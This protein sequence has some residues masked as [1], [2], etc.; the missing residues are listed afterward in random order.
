MVAAFPL[1]GPPCEPESV[2]WGLDGALAASSSLAVSSGSVPWDE[3]WHD[4]P[5]AV[6]ATGVDGCVRA[7]ASSTLAAGLFWTV[8]SGRLLFGPRLAEVIAA[9]RGPTT[10]SHQWLRGQLLLTSA[11]SQTPYNEV[12]RLPPAT[13]ATWRHGRREPELTVVSGPETWPPP[14]LSGEHA[15]PEYL[16]AFD[17]AV[18]HMAGDAGPICAT[19][20][21]GLDSTFVVASL[22]RLAS[23]SRP[24]H[25]FSY[26]PHPDADLRSDGLWD[27]DDFAFAK[28]VAE[29]YSGRVVLVPL[30]NDVPTQP[31]DSAAASAE[32]LWFPLQNPSNNVWIDAARAHASALGSKTLFMGEHGNSAFSFDHPYAAGYYL[33][34][35]NASAMTELLRAEKMKGNTT[36]QGLKRAWIGPLTAPMRSRH[37]RAKAPLPWWRATPGP[38][39]PGVGRTQYLNWLGGDRSQRAQGQ[40]DRHGTV[41]A[42]PFTAARVLEVAARI[43][44][45]EWRRGPL[46]R[47]FARRA[48]V[49][50]VP[51]EVRLRTRRGGQSWDTWFII[52]NQRERYLDETAALRTTPVLSELVD[53]DTMLTD[54][55]SWAWGEVRGPHRGAVSTA[56]RLLHLGH[57]TRMTL[58]RL[59]HMARATR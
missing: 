19:L 41:V 48:G 4:V 8:D 47:S 17:K 32:D 29:H 38:L 16:R 3:K 31:L 53:V 37:R 26:R 40:P 9:R 51:D 56:V 1:P 33:H 30:V 10:F 54:L 39:F 27:P 15:V 22:A 45:F 18:D 12:H 2:V 49:G 50:R 42:D 59:E 14:D 6:T 43:E 24:I 21:G 23:T 57:F 20:S 36:L 35:R 44:P 34:Q 58:Q 5:C 52:R 28:R 55:Q 13:L 11:P 25:A 7:Y 46:N